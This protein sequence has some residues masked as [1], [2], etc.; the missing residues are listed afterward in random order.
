M[1]ELQKDIL[2]YQERG[3]V[4]V[5]V[6]SN[7]WIGEKPSIIHNEENETEIRVYPRTSQKKE[8]NKQ[9]EWFLSCMNQ[10]NMIVL[11][12]LRNRAEITYDHPGR[13]ATSVVDFVVVDQTTHQQTSDII[14]DDLRYDLDT[15]HMMLSVKVPIKQKKRPK[16][17]EKPRG[18]VRPKSEMKILKTVMIQDVFWKVLEKNCLTH[19]GKY[20]TTENLSLDEE[21]VKFK[22]LLHTSLKETLRVCQPRRIFLSARLRSTPEIIS[23]RVKKNK[24]VRQRKDEMSREE[25]LKL[26]TRIHTLDRELKKRIRREREKW[27]TDQLEEIE[28]LKPEDC[29]RMWKELKTLSNWTTREPL[30]QLRTKGGHGRECVGSLETNI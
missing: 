23:L 18:N 30:P 16:T 9:G 6:D 20:E 24:L 27:K 29:R 2:S 15:D 4:M 13:E 17:K 14:H 19:V 21:Y 28:Q 3:R 11:N 1:E 7:G 5:F 10:T 25:R 8:T 26:T 22:E 12:G